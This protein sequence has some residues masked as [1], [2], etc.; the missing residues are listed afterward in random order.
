MVETESAEDGPFDGRRFMYYCI[1]CLNYSMAISVTVLVYVSPRRQSRANTGRG[2]VR[3]R[4]WLV[5]WIKRQK[6]YWSSWWKFDADVSR[7]QADSNEWLGSM[8]VFEMR[9]IHWASQPPKFFVKVTRD[10]NLVNNLG[11]T[12]LTDL[13]GYLVSQY[14]Y[15]RKIS[16]KNILVKFTLGLAP[17]IGCTLMWLLQTWWGDAFALPLF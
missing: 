1:F 14:Q 6:I 4:L 7:F 16:P 10:K 9:W 3:R 15:L 17:F 8:D 2:T 13:D 5:R 11:S 12:S